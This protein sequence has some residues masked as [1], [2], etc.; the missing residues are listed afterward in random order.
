MTYLVLNDNRLL[1]SNKADER[2]RVDV[3]TLDAPPK[4][5]RL[6]VLSTTLLAGPSDTLLLEVLF[7]VASVT[8]GGASLLLVLMPLFI[9]LIV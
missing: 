1:P 4:E 8:G 2:S 6:S 5:H 9:E 3:T 7:E